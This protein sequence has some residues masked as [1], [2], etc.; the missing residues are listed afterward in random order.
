MASS[1]TANLDTILGKLVVEQGL[2]TSEEVSA[3]RKLVRDKQV[4]AK[5]GGDKASA[6]LV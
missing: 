5:E 1:E 2:A 3:C 6:S 4:K